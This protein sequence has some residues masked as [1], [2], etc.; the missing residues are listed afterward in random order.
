[1]RN[2]AAWLVLVFTLGC[3][4]CGLGSLLEVRPLTL[5]AFLVCQGWLLLALVLAG[6]HHRLV[7]GSEVHGQ[8]VVR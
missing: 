4:W 8:R 1:M 6:V 5:K 2:T 7:R 3:V